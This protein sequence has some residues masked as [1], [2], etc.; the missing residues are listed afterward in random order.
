M[1]IRD[2]ILY[3]KPKSSNKSILN[4]C[5]IANAI[6]FIK[7]FDAAENDDHSFITNGEDSNEDQ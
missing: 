1:S 2:N 4:A 3:S 7:E 5:E 6:D